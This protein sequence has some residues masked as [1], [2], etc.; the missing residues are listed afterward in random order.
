MNYLRLLWELYTQKRNTAKTREQIKELQEKKSCKM[1]RFAYQN[2]AFYRQSFEA[3][4]ISEENI[5]TS[6]FLF[7]RLLI[8]RRSLPTLMML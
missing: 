4:G 6:P 5:D 2:S 7:F 3:E 1:P 8:K